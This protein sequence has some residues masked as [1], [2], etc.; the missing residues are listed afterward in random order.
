MTA[1]AVD[2]CYLGNLCVPDFVV[3][4][5]YFDGLSAQVFLDAF[6]AWRFPADFART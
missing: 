2:G 3:S 6:K 5:E 1:G 4:A